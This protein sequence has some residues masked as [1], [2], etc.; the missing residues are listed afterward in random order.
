MIAALPH[1][2]ATAEAGCLTR[3]VDGSSVAPATVMYTLT[4]VIGTAEERKQKCKSHNS[5]A[6]SHT[7]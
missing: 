7:S 2:H 1:P 5:H 6:R 3:A 4:R